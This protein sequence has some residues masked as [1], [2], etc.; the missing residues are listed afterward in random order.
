MNE[1]WV[2]LHA[3]HQGDLDPLIA[4]AVLPAVRGLVEDGLAG[5]WFFLRY[6]EAGSHVRVRV[7]TTPEGRGAV[8][9]KLAVCLGSY[10][11][12]HPSGPWKD[13]ELYPG[14]AGKLAAYEGLDTCERELRPVDTVA[15]IPYRPERDAYG[16]GSSLAAVE[17]HFCD[18][19]RLAATVIESRTSASR[20]RGLALE[21]AMTMLAVVRPDLPEVAAEYAAGVDRTDGPPLRSAEL[22]RA[23]LAQ[24]DRLRAQISAAWSA[25]DD[26]EWRRSIVRLTRE[27]REIDLDVE[28]PRSPLAWQ[29]SPTPIEG[30]L[31]RCTHLFNNRVGVSMADEMYVTY[32]MARA[33]A[34]FGGRRSR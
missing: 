29:V 23:Y 28:P 24:R 21:N 1:I 19:S 34:E 32:L 3:F 11:D 15:S 7:S 12:A 13:P 6:W 4:E 5:S 14:L 25:D 26:S 2:S 22:H 8:E 30:I 18:S 10:L 31:M 9:S 20:R 27:L 17:R 33:L 16:D